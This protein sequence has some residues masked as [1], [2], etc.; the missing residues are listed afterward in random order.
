MKRA[1][2]F[3]TGS[4]VFDK[5][6]QT[7]NFLWWEGHKRRSTVIGT[8]Q[9]FPTKNA[10]R[11][12]APSIDSLKEVPKSQNGAPTVT[13]L[14]EQYRAEEMPTRYS[15]RRSYEAW[16]RNHIVPEWGDHPITDLQARPVELWLQSL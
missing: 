7:W 11:R 8:R 1:Q 2:R 13:T 3:Q 10:A 9:E 4:V 15:T 5:R 14:V 16:F 6:R 12:A